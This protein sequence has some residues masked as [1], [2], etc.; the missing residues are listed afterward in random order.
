M[1]SSQS[2]PFAVR[3]TSLKYG[4]GEPVKAYSPPNRYRYPS[5]DDHRRPR[6]C[7]PGRGRGDLG[8]VHAVGGAP[9]VVEQLPGRRPADDTRV[10]VDRAPEHVDLSVQH[11]SAQPGPAGPGRRRGQPGP[12]GAV[13][14]GPDVVEELRAGDELREAER[15]GTARRVGV[16]Q[17]VLPAEQHHAVTLHDHLVVRAGRPA[18]GLVV[19]VHL[20]P[21]RTQVVAAPGVA[22]D[23]G[24]TRDGAGGERHEAVG[25]ATADQVH[26]TVEHDGL[27]TGP[28]SPGRVRR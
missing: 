15:V 3:H 13:G 16:Q 25:G 17:E 18:V 4:G 5:R 8:P 14:A 6:P 2:A 21:A 19:A 22:P 24:V 1:T 12:V 20:R 28:P 9:H 26:R 23:R 11:R 10:V 7:R 27:D